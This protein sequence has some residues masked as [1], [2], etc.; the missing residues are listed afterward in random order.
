MVE[1][2]AN[3]AVLLEIPERLDEHAERLEERLRQDQD[4]LHVLEAEK[5]KELAGHD[6]TEALR[7]ARD[8]ESE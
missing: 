3:Y 5:I 2:R 7:Q 1:A 4:A 8:E 6:L